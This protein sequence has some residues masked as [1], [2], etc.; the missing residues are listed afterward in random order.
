MATVVTAGAGCTEHCEERVEIDG[1]LEG[2]PLATTEWDG[3][4]AWIDGTLW[5]FDPTKV[6]IGGLAFLLEDPTGEDSARFTYVST[7]DAE[8]GVVRGE[9][10]LLIY[11]FEARDR[12]SVGDTIPISSMAAV[13]AA[14][15]QA[16]E[17]AE[18]EAWRELL[19][20]MRDDPSPSALAVWITEPTKVDPLFSA[21]S[22]GAT[23]GEARIT[24]A[25]KRLDGTAISTF[26][27]GSG[28]LLSNLRMSYEASITFGTGHVDM[29]VRCEGE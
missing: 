6:V 13:N 12:L 1:T 5:D 20:D 10:R 7:P 9:Q 15:A 22:L 2:E 11:V 27:Q 8:L 16:D 28:G 26:T 14:R 25:V 19:D 21:A 3:Q 23:A 24:E 29:V 18:A 4:A 17:E